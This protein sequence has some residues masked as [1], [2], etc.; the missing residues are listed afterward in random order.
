[1]RKHR[2]KGFIFVLVIMTLASISAV[3]YILTAHANTM[4]FQTD[5]AYLKA[6]ERN[7]TASALAWARHNIENQNAEA[8][9]KPA[10]L[11]TTNLTTRPSTLSITVS[12]PQSDKPQAEVITSATRKRRTLKSRGKYAV[13]L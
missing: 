7:L 8:L 2:E 13:N 11:D 5:T 4:L 1:M 9:S 10:K 6:T 3:I 12:D